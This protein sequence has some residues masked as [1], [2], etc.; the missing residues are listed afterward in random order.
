MA[1]LEAEEGEEED[2]ILEEEV[3]VEMKTSQC[4]W[5]MDRCLK[6]RRWRILKRGADHHGHLVS[7]TRR[8]VFGECTSRATR[9]RVAIRSGLI[10]E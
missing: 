10:R 1:A 2:P 9:Q 4:W 5:L 8:T 3:V 7:V 6:G